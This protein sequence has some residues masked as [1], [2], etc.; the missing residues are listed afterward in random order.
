MKWSEEDDVIRRANA[1]ESGL[2]ASIW[3]RDKIQAERMAQQLQA[4]NV[5]VNCHAEMQPN[6]PFS[7]HKQSG[8][9][10]EMG[11]EGLKS[12][13]SVQSVYIRHA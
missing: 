1:T 3:T 2:G 11:V 12:Y 4:G 8:M 6:I 9:G 5:W 10:V 7:G 13:C